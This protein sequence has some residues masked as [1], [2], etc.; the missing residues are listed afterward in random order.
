LVLVAV[1]ILFL[2]GYRVVFGGDTMVWLFFVL[3]P[4]LLILLR[5][6]GGDRSRLIA[7]ER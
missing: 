4:L 5:A 2:G 6:T 7:P 3:I 1:E